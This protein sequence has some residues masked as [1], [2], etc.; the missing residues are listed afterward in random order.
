MKRIVKTVLIITVLLTSY[1]Y[2]SIFLTKNGQFI[3]YNNENSMSIEMSKEK[4][5]FLYDNPQLVNV[6]DSLNLFQKTFTIW[7]DKC[8]RR[9]R[10]GFLPIGY[11]FSIDSLRVLNITFKDMDSKLF[12][13]TDNGN[14]HN[15]YT[16]DGTRHKKGLIRLELFNDKKEKLAE[17]DVEIK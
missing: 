13:K 8:R 7:I 4:D 15:A 2:L 5:I 10:Y 16:L 1:Y 14:F 12:I 11:S 17:C 9:K 3:Q 6:N